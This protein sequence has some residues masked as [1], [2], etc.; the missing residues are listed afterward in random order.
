MTSQASGTCEA[1]D[2]ATFAGEDS[3]VATVVGTVL[4][5]VGYSHAAVAVWR[6]LV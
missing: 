1:G 6:V 5:I 3:F 4:Y 2:V